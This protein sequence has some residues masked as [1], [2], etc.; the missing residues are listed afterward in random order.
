MTCAAS[1][2]LFDEQGKPTELGKET[3]IS[4]KISPFKNID[5][6]EGKNMQT[7]F[8]EYLISKGKA[9]LVK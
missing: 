5:E 1:Y 6:Y 3:N 7:L 8:K 4:R 2:K 9:E